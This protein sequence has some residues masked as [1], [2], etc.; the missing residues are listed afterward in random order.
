[1]GAGVGVGAR[2]AEVGVDVRA[3]VGAEIGEDVG[4]VAG[5]QT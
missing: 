4:A 1:M 2:I 5:A 3:I